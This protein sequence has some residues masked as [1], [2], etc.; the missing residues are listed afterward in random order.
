QRLAGDLAAHV[1]RR[2]VSRGA[3]TG[4][5]RL[6]PRLRSIR[7]RIAGTGRRNEHFRRARG[8]GGGNRQ[9]RA[10]QVARPPDVRRPACHYLPA[11]SRARSRR[12]VTAV[13][14]SS[15]RSPESARSNA[16]A[17]SRYFFIWK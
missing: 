4:A 14:S 9:A 17:A 3:A 8:N 11:S 10:K 1:Q 13:T 12:L 5:R 2:R 6:A 16:V 7:K 15:S